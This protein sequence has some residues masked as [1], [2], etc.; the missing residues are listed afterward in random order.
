MNCVY[1]AY[2]DHLLYIGQEPNRVDWFLYSTIKSITQSPN[3]YTYNGIVPFMVEC[4]AK[5]KNLDVR[6]QHRLWTKELCLAFAVS[7]NA[8]M[9]MRLGIIAGDFQEEVNKITLEPAIYLLYGW[10][11]AIFSA[12]VP[13]RGIPV[14]AIQLSDKKEKEKYYDRSRNKCISK[15]AECSD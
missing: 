3:D 15:C 1:R 9:L 4:M 5:A 7:D 2:V 10:R 6:I 8:S 12:V 11:H 14:M 13:Y